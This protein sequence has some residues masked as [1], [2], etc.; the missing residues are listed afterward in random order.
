MTTINGHTTRAV[1]TVLTAA[2]YNA[3]HV[4]HVTNAQ[5]LNAAKMEGATPPVVDGGFVAW[6]GTGG[7][8]LKSAVSPPYVVGGTDVPISDGG[9]GQSTALL[10]FN[11]LKQDMTEILSGVA[12][13]ATDAEIRAATTGAKAMMAEDLST[14][15]AAVALTHASP[16]TIDWAA[17]INFTWAIT[18]SVT[19]SNPTNGQPGTWRRL[20][21]TQDGT[22]S[23]VVT[24]GNQYVHPGG[25]DAVLSTTASA[26]DTLYIYCRTASI[27]E[28]HVGGKAWAT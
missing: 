23:R 4:N 22:G 19:L 21:I 26:V 15:A 8:A 28:V 12:E 13:M 24:W 18:A 14:A 5:A 16:T 7:N 3:D 17:G 9:T 11:A 25:I 27:F 2:I 1:G 10:G 20:Q 6:S